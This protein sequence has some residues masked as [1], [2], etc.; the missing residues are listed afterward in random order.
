M[1]TEVPEVSFSRCYESTECKVLRSYDKKV[2]KF[3][4]VQA[5]RQ[6]VHLFEEVLELSFKR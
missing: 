2:T 1:E 4:R 3:S 5:A 6:V